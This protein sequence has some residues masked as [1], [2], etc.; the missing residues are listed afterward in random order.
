MIRALVWVVVISLV[1]V[2]GITMSRYEAELRTPAPAPT[3][4]EE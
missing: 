1:F 2:L 3:E 4:I